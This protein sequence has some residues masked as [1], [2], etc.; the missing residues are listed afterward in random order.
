MLKD[1]RVNIIMVFDGMANLSKAGTE[2]KRRESRSQAKS[3]ARELMIAGKTEEARKEFAKAVEINHQHA[4]ALME[5]CR[6]E[7]VD[8]ITSMYEADA[9]LA[10]LNKIGLADYVISEDSDLI[11]FGC[12]KIVFK[13]QLD[14]SCLFYDSKNLHETIGLSEEKFSFEKFRR[15][16]I[17]SGCDYLDSLPGIG[18]AKASKFMLMTAETDMRRALLKIPSYLNMS[19]KLTVTPE[20][21]EGFL[22]AEATFK[23]MF[24]YDP[25]KRRMVRLNEF[26]NE[27]EDIQY[28]SQAGQ[29]I[30]EDL[31]YQ[32][33]LGNI[34]PRTLVEVAN[35]N[36]KTFDSNASIWKSSF[37]EYKNKLN[38]QPSKAKQQNKITNFIPVHKNDGEKVREFIEKEKVVEDALGM[39][40]LIDTYSS[41]QPCSSK[42]ESPLDVNSE[43]FQD[44]ISPSRNPFAKRTNTIE[45]LE[46]AEAS[47]TSLI[48]K[49]VT[50]NPP[51][52]IS[53]LFKKQEPLK[54]T[55]EMRESAKQNT[56][57]SKKQLEV[58][59]DENLKFYQLTK[60]SFKLKTENDTK[61]P[62]IEEINSRNSEPIEELN[63]SYS[64]PIE[65]DGD[66][67]TDAFNIQV[68]KEIR[69]LDKLC[70]SKPTKL[71]AISQKPST[72]RKTG[73]KRK[74]SQPS[75]NGSQQL[76]LA[77]FGFVPKT[78]SGTT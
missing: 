1:N 19:N 38:H 55:K 39:Y 78:F 45:Q 7:K 10:Y 51:R 9:Q 54:I 12:N 26:E 72:S 53:R 25:I 52:V 37:Q 43:D 2:K 76:K 44:Q 21:I 31:A 36:P 20:Y 6:K 68:M 11:L 16:A 4:L 34:N 65:I 56:E 47:S 71:P 50:N 23:Y 77:K 18:L 29:E 67:D 3:R 14:G 28:C 66:D 8:C 33:A 74:A 40:F 57:E 64:E 69:M 59:L 58:K 27:A 75:L 63:S 35:F 32:L 15:I 22:K 62:L 70:D 24:V 17:L 61:E 42:K 46:S 5:A 60:Y 13:L 30:D 41:Q 49:F 48:K 73:I